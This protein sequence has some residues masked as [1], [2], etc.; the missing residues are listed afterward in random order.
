MGRFICP[1]LQRQMS[2][3]MKSPVENPVSTVI[4]MLGLSKSSPISYPRKS[5]P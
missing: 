4:S 2:I 5:K 1:S 3:A